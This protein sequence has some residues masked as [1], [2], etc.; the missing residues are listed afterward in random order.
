MPARMPYKDMTKAMA[1]GQRICARVLEIIKTLVEK[2]VLSGLREAPSLRE[3]GM[4][5]PLAKPAT[6]QA[7]SSAG[8]WLISRAAAQA[9][10][11]INAPAARIRPGRRGRRGEPKR[12]M[13]LVTQK[14]ERQ[15]AAIAGLF[16]L[17]DT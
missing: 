14:R 2:P 13:V 11:E 15:R 16:R 10:A 17:T 9:A 7:A 4:Q 6:Q 12:L 8:G 1:M 3:R 5:E